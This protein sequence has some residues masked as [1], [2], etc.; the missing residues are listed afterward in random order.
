MHNIGKNAQRLKKAGPAE[1]SPTPGNDIIHGTAG[2]DYIT[3]S[4]GGNDEF[5]GEGGDDILYA[6]RNPGVTGSVLLDGGDDNDRLTFAS[7]FEVGSVILRGGSGRDLIEASG[8]LTISVDAGADADILNIGREGTAY[9]I[10]LGTGADIISFSGVE[11]TWDPGPAMLLTDF[12]TGPGGDRFAFEQ[13]LA[14]LVGWNPTLSPFATGHL[15]LVQQGADTVLRIDRDGTGSAFPTIDFAIFQGR[16][17]TSF[18]VDNVGFALDGGAT[19]GLILSGTVGEDRIYGAGGDDLID[20]GGEHDEIFGGAG[21]DVIQG[22]AGSDRLDGQF[23]DDRLHGG[24][25]ADQLSEDYGG[26]DRLYGEGGGDIIN[27]TRVRSETATDI[28]AEGGE[29][30]DSLYFFGL[31]SSRVHRLTY[32]GGTGDDYI[33][34]ESGVATAAVD[35]GEG[36]DDLYLLLNDAYYTVTLGAGADHVRLYNNNFAHAVLQH[37]RFTDFQAGAGGDILE[38]STSMLKGK[39]LTWN[40]TTDPFSLGLLRL[41][42]RGTDAMILADRD[43]DGQGL[44]TLVTFANL[45]AAS[46]VAANLFGF[47][48]GSV[49]NMSGDEDETFTGGTGPDVFN[50][51]GGN[52]T[53]IGAGGGDTLDG[54]IGNDLLFSGTYFANWNNPNTIPVLDTG[55][56]VDT[57]RGQAGDDVL[58]AGYGDN[59]DGGADYDI[60]FISFRGAAAGIT[61]DFA[62]LAAGG[63]LNIGGG[64]IQ[65]VERLRWVEGSEFADNFTME[66]TG[67]DGATVY[68]R[69]GDDTI[70]AAMGTGEIYGG[71][72]NDTIDSS[73]NGYGRPVYGEAGNDVITSGFGFAYGGTGNDTITGGGRLF[74]D[75][76]NDTLTA[77][78]LSGSPYL[79]G[80]AGD[81]NLTGSGATDYLHGEAGADIIDGGGGNDTL[82]SAGYDPVLVSS[83]DYGAEHDVVNGGAGDDEIIIGY[84]DDADGGDG[85][86]TLVMTL[87]GAPAGVTLNLNIGGSG[88]GGVGNIVNFEK[89][90]VLSGTDFADT[91]TV[92]AF[93]GQVMISGRDGNDVL[94]ATTTSVYFLGGAGSDIL[95]G[96]SAADSMQASVG[97]DILRGG[98][99]NDSLDGEDGDDF[100]EGGLGDDTLKG[101]IGVDTVSYANES[102]GVIVHLDRAGQH[103]LGA[104]F[105]DQ[106]ES[107]EN[108]IG[109]AF[110]DE[111]WGSFVSNRLEGGGGNDWLNGK[112]GADVL[113]GGLGD[114][115]YI[116]DDSGDQAVEAA[117]EGV[118]LVESSVTFTLGAAVENLTLTGNA[119]LNGTGNGEANVL[120][121]NSGANLLSGGGND[122]Q[123]FGGLGNDILNG[124]GGNDMLTGEDGGDVLDGGA[125]A[126]IVYG[127][128]GN[129]IA[130]V[131]GGTGKADTGL[132]QVHLGADLDRLIVNYAQ[133]TEAVVMTNPIYS[134]GAEAV[135]AIDG[136]TRLA[137]TG[138]E[139]LTI[140]T[141]AGNDVIYGVA[142]P[143]GTLLDDIATGGGNDLI[144]SVAGAGIDRIDGGAGVD[145]AHS[146]DWSDLDASIAV[147]FD[148]NIASGVTIGTG[149]S[150]RWLRGIEQLVNFTSGAGNDV[151]A[152]S[153]DAGLH[154]VLATGA[155]NDSVTWHGGATAAATAA[156][157][158]VSMGENA[159]DDDWLIVDFGAATQRI[160]FGAPPTIIASEAAGVIRI[161]GL[162]RLS[163]DGVERLWLTS[164]VG[165]DELH[166]AIGADRLA[167]GTGDDLYHVGQSG[168][169][170]I[171]AA[172]G[173]N[174]RILA[175]TSYALAADAEV[176]TLEAVFGSS[177]INLTGN[178]FAQILIGNAGA[179]MLDGGAG[180][181]I[182]RGL[183]G[184]DSY[185][186]DTLDDQVIEAGG[187]GTDTILTAISYQL[188]AG[189]SIENLAAR[190]AGLTIPL[191][192]IGNDLA[193]VITGNAGANLLDGGAGADS[194]QGGGGDDTYFVDSFGDQVIEAAGQ[195]SDKV[196]TTVTYQL[197]A[198]QSVELLAARDN[199]LTTAMNLIGNEL[200]NVIFGNSGANFLDGGAGADIMTGF[201]GDDIYAIDNAGDVVDE[202]Q[203]GGNDAIYTSFSYVLGLGASIEILA[204]RD[205]SLTVA[206]NLFGNELNNI[207]FGNSGANF[208]D[209]GT[210]ADIMT[211]FGGDDVYA[212]DNA[213]DVVDEGQNGG[214]D[215]IYTNFSYVLGFG[216]SVEILAARDNSATT[217]MNLFGNEL[218]NFIFGNNGANFLDGQVGADTMTGFGGDDIYVVDNANDRVVENSGGGADAIYTAFSYTLAATHSIETLAARDNSLTVALDLTGNELANNVLGNNGANVL[219]GDGGADVL[220]GFGGADMFAFTTAAAAGNAD[221]IADFLS[222]TDKLA[223]DDAIFQGIGT[224]GSF[225]ANAFVAGTAA[226]DADDRIIYNAANGQL[227]YDA[228]G[229]GAGAAVLLATLQGNPALTVSDFQVI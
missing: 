164:G 74:G 56:E 217:A 198:G 207:I 15:A 94:T 206:M 87:L 223:L 122:D 40:G 176:E 175:G 184:D 98:G 193:N 14:K 84:G 49:T 109:S 154:N 54:G 167:G 139:A 91:I 192:L 150:Q 205:N 116:V 211:G 17:A 33:S 60:L 5:Y 44:E 65:N 212:I 1:A 89:L 28:L 10:A 16:L 143:G 162:G 32:N 151:I 213:G 128:A 101:G 215:T 13:Y 24:D 156:G 50:G 114:D 134:L 153:S 118:D 221:Y 105:L 220:L 95:T 26:N 121:G 224:P 168:D 129:D 158:S 81:D 100:L 111:L 4:L 194:L 144:Y 203:N 202:G 41:A 123:V 145:T 166:G 186:V 46:L 27:V 36:D 199:S 3:D 208:I 88:V 197:A 179:N 75:D 22:G 72:G 172:G 19:P 189:T 102:G 59:V 142:F 43:G 6:S 31:T 8:G 133:M 83:F 226:A 96:S 67:G 45:N 106:L 131:S 141:G 173:G 66:N 159:N 104:G 71:D 39:L 68:G 190:N 23:G 55:T 64:L 187:E 185:A 119:N 9:T 62:A 228:D 209:G 76:G 29:G 61:A 47:Q 85:I 174:D 126:D 82:Y 90:S 63:T 147:A 183:G 200:A 93:Q 177:A 103:V 125:G 222:G 204:A 130:T 229:S 51:L 216:A 113:A 210:G 110:A 152:L 170:V 178:A 191:S 34:I 188:G 21:N 171:E 180:G 120:R 79:Y 70:V 86:D 160:D 155:G 117:D 218:D 169:Q 97:N 157:S 132:D 146:V 78:S 52:D 53:L 161:D 99:G 92:G 219:N 2:A 225:N 163:F 77:V 138:L 37:L 181:D 107:I 227:L 115:T 35:A 140:T 196:Y 148:A 135:F 112:E 12:E 58:V 11:F 25:E 80:G 201:G 127:G 108:A 18:T 7:D 165:N 136:A 124:D 182:M 69:G 42:Q 73:S 30:R 20:G 214:A 137:V 195:G 57:L 48:P 38:F 149:N